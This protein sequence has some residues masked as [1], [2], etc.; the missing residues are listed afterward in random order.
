MHVGKKLAVLAMLLPL[1]A[2][3]QGNTFDKVRYGWRL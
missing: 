1:L 2:H 3:A